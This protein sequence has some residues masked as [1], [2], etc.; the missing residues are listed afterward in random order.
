LLQVAKLV[1]KC[2]S[3]VCCVTQ[4]CNDTLKEHFGTFVT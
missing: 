3:S 4:I 2:V 1:A